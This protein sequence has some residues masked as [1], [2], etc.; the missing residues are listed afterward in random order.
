MLAIYQTT[1]ASAVLIA[2]EQPDTGQAEPLALALR[3]SLLVTSPPAAL[4]SP[5]F[6]R[7]ARRSWTPAACCWPSGCARCCPRCPIRTPRTSCPSFQARTR[8][9]PP[10]SPPPSPGARRPRRSSA[11]VSPHWASKACR[12]R[13]C[14]PP[15][16]RA[17]RADGRGGPAPARE[18][19]GTV[20]QG[21]GGRFRS[22][23]FPARRL[24]QRGP[25]RCRPARPRPG[26]R[27]DPGGEPV[28]RRLDL[29]APCLDLRV[30]TAPAVQWE[31]VVTIQNPDVKP[32]PFPSP[33]GFLDDGGPTLLGAATS[34]SC[35]WRRRRCSTR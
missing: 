18:H 2:G 6:R 10:P 5:A 20:Q 14:P 26:R 7:N 17:R 13:R 27:Q 32:Y 1:Q 4:L 23:A 19:A 16:G 33:A 25:V 30:F 21:H 3:N 12:S 34:R 29:V 9:S 24:R 22:R 28:H 31:P 15:R 35:R 11:S 8:R